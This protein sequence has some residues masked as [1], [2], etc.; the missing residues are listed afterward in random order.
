MIDNAI[1]EKAKEKIVEILI[2]TFATVLWI[3]PIDDVTVELMNNIGAQCTLI[4]HSGPHDT[5]QINRINH[6]K[7]IPK[8][9]R[10][11]GPF[12]DLISTPSIRDLK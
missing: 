7:I 11:T 10:I 2:I 12:M 6:N 1:K 3:I 4:I 8:I 5:T 9:N